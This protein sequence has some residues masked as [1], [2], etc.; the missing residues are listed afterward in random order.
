M[1][2][3]LNELPLNLKNNSPK[4]LFQVGT[5]YHFE[6]IQRSDQVFKVSQFLKKQQSISINKRT[7]KSNNSFMVVHSSWGGYVLYFNNTNKKWE[8]SFFG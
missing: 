1:L 6:F 3:S 2:V 7:D 4:D 5:N 8:I